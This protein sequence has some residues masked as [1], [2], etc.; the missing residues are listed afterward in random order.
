MWRRIVIACVAAV[1]PLLTLAHDLI[2]RGAMVNP[3]RLEAERDNAKLNFLASQAK[4]HGV[5]PKAVKAARSV[6]YDG[7]RWL[8]SDLKICFWNGGEQQ[9][10]EVMQI[11]D[12]WHQAVPSI[13]FNYIENGSFRIC[14][15][16]DLLDFH[17]MADIR[18]ALTDDSRPL[19]SA[20]DISM[21]RGDWAYP[22]RAMA[23]DARFPT[24]VNLVGA[25]ELRRKQMLSD[26]YFNVRHEF[27][28][29]L[30]L[31]HEHQ[32]GV[33]KGWFDVKAI[34]RDTGWTESFAALQVNA[35]DESSNAFGF[36]GAYDPQSIMQYN[37][38]LGWYM[39]DKP[40]QPNPCH[41]RN[42]VDDLSEM[43]KYVIAAIYQPNLNETAER[44]N[45]LLAANREAPVRQ[46]ST[47]PA[48]EMGSRTSQTQSV[49]VALD[50]F[51]RRVRQASQISIQVY[52][53]KADEKAVLSA[54]SNLGYPLKDKAGNPVRNISTNSN[55]TLRGDPTNTLLYTNDVSDQDVRY[56]ALS[57]VRAG[58]AIK[59]IQ[60]YFPRQRNNFAIRDHL[61]QIGADV[62]NRR[63]AALSVGDILE[64][65]LPL[66]G[67][68]K[69]P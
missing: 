52:P 39:P 22:G 8:K 28:H 30:S 20:Q 17:K 26:Y 38:A 53:H 46:P 40:S 58:I 55:A 34:S 31:V 62:T 67:E 60:P 35:I 18:I 37:F 14:K 3:P 9:Q 19:W 12:V 33:C 1:L 25:M 23:Q 45:L 29:A 10:R 15:L 50:E 5:D 63:R 66:F 2:T 68:R 36:I 7:Y 64:R 54:L 21:K 27:G 43:D 32:R 16:E 61:I 56:V 48:A 6:Y 4:R 49:E 59:S 42:Q 65:P 69:S 13:A 51:Q 47:S 24:T 41:R 57:L 11:A 44:R